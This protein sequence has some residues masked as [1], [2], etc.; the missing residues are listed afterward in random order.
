MR[1]EHEYDAFKK[2]IFL[3]LTYEDKELTLVPYSYPADINSAVFVVDNVPKVATLNKTDIQSFFKVLRRELLGHNLKYYLAGEYGPGTNRPHFHII[4]LGLSILN[5]NHLVAIEK[6]W[7][8][9][10]W[11]PQR[12]TFCYGTV[13]KPSIRYTCKYINKR[14][15]SKDADKMKQQFGNRL[16]EFQLV[17]KGIGLSW[18]IRN[19]KEIEKTGKI[20]YR[21]KERPIP[22]YYKKH[23][24][25]STDVMIKN[26]TEYINE[27]C[28][29]YNVDKKLL[30]VF[31]PFNGQLIDKRFKSEVIQSAVNIESAVEK[32]SKPDVIDKTWS[33][34]RASQ[35]A[36]R[37]S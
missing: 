35:Q 19:A 36:K 9:C 5:K 25:L 37:G 20:M 6:S 29:K 28:E 27:L 18:C 34:D 3:T 10:I 14:F 33:L 24:S 2:G 8:K 15:F 22:E 7:K 23:L 31:N 11:T 32:F 13:S 16:P 1:L 12:R 17:S 21:T 26:R 30:G 4:L